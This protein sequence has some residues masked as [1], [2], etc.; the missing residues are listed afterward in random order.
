MVITHN[1]EAATGSSLWR[2]LGGVF[3]L[4]L[5]VGYTTT[6]R[7]LCSGALAAAGVPA[8]GRDLPQ[9]LAAPARRRRRDGRDPGA[10]AGT[11]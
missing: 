3:S 4:A 2:I 5:L 7:T 9:R 11:R 8:P 1:T 10:A 6:I